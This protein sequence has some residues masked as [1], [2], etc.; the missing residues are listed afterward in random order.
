LRISLFIQKARCPHMQPNKPF[1]APAKSSPP[2]KRAERP[3]VPLIGA[4][5]ANQR[6]VCG[7]ETEKKPSGA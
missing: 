2:P 1:Q 4:P 3:A 6:S 5:A 7:G